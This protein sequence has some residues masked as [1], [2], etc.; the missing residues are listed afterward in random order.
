MES[1]QALRCSVS[2]VSLGLIICQVT[3]QSAH[4]LL[5]SFFKKM[6]N[7]IFFQKKLPAK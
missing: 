1:S 5:C 6:V 2:T 4:E 3:R 7:L